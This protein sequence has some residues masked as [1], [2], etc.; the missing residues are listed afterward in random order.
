MTIPAPL[1]VDVAGD[2]CLDLVGIPIPPQKPTSVANNW[3][4]TGETRTY[5]LPGGAMLLADWIGTAVATAEVR[6]MRPLI[7]AEIA[8]PPAANTP[9]TPKQFFDIAERLT[10]NEVVHSLMQLDHFKTKPDDKKK[11]QVRVAKQLGYSGPHGTN[12]KLTWLP[13]E[14]E[15]G[16]VQLL[17]LDDTGNRFRREPSQWPAVLTQPGEKRPLVI[18]KLHRPLPGT[19]D[20]SEQ[21]VKNELWE[22]VKIGR[23]HV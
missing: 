8:G 3:Q 12:P 6:P 4:L 9:L 23:A 17:V 19:K 14:S 1:R 13:P 21:P 16:T 10:R 7:P 11:E 15:P 20:A 5:Y 22:A 18:Y 2:V